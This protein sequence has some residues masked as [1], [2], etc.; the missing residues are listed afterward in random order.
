MGKR[1]IGAS[2]IAIRPTPEVLANR[3]PMPWE[4]AGLSRAERVAVFLETLPVTSGS[5][6][7]TK[8]RLR[9]WQWKEIIEPIYATNSEGRRY[10]REAVISMPRKNGKT[11]IVT[12]LALCHL[13][14]P[15]SL[16][17]GQ[18]VSAANA[19]K[20]SGLIFNEMAAIVNRTPWMKE[21]INVQRFV[22]RMEDLGIT[23]STY[24]ALA[25]EVHTEYGQSLSFWIYDELGQAKNR[26]LYNVLSSSGGAWEE[27]LGIIISTQAPI[28]MHI[29]SELIDDGLQI[30]NGVVDDPSRYACVFAA[31]DDADPW[32]EA[33]W[34]GCNPALGDFRGLDDMRDFAKK[35][36]RIPAMEATFRNLY[37]NQ[38]VAAD[39]EFIPQALW[40]KCG[41]DYDA[42]SLEGRSCYGGLDLSGTGK[43]D[44][45]SLV[46]VFEV[47]DDAL[48]VLPF[49][50]C[51]SEGVESA[52]HKDRVPYSAWIKESHV[53]SVDGRIF[54]YH[55]LAVKLAELSIR[56]KIEAIGV[57]PWAFDKM[58]AELNEI[59]ADLTFKKH[60]QHIKAMDPSVTC[61][62]NAIISGRLRHNKNP[63][64]RWCVSNVKV[65]RDS[66]GNRKFDK[67]KAT[68]RI[69][70]AV[71]LA[72]ACGIQAS[73]SDSAEPSYAVTLI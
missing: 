71:S 35:A 52:E 57:D 8:F 63:V 55:A 2:P 65:L 40:V 43:N 18:V 62:E 14:G 59:G 21:R 64:L 19:K 26:E 70:G 72:M 16:G 13:V 68:G 15:E 58:E 38:R 39:E 23:D 9:E 44:L 60:D 33:T 30:R 28:S 20:Q 42:K 17:R 10:V 66:S 69:D 5:K 29:M 1:G 4:K 47:E 37:L 3:D 7:G 46:L 27:P 50:W 61:L 48:K 31:P 22:K 56:Y 67:R 54:D 53:L 12:G 73:M 49:F 24:E 32:D 34:F 6:R 11:G 36:K 45:T 25:A 41:D 51:A